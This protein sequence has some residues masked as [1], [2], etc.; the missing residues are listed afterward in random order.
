M[1]YNH[2]TRAFGA[3][4]T[5]K[6]QDGRTYSDT[7]K[8]DDFAETYGNDPV[9]C[10]QPG[11]VFA[12]G[13]SGTYG[14]YLWVRR[15]D[16]VVVKYH[17]FSSM[18]SIGIGVELSPGQILGYSGASADNASGNHSHIQV[19]VGGVPVNPQ[20]YIWQYIGS[21]AGGW[22]STPIEDD[23]TPEQANQLK[24]VYDAILK[25][26]PDMPDKGR[27]IGQSLAGIVTVVDQIKANV[28]QTVQRT[29]SD[30]KPYPV[31]QIQELADAKTVAMEV[32]TLVQQLIANPTPGTGPATITESDIDAIAE[33]VAALIT[34]TRLTIE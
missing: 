22:A 31:T 4:R 11:K 7:H 26:G 33:K 17:M 24:F 30:G 29:G 13:H 1:L 10:I 6:G 20:P 8:G 21:P 15:A 27:S 23:M 5:W 14:Y 12:R 3:V 32:R 18:P 16:G 34:R 9:P 28:T 19:E 25:G 2:R